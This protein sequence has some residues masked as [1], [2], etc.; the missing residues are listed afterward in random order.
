ML[1]ILVLVASFVFAV[2]AQANLLVNGDFEDGLNGWGS[3]FGSVQVVNKNG[4][5]VA[6]LNDNNSSGLEVLWQSFY[7]PTEVNTVSF[8]FDFKFK[9]W[10]NSR[11]QEDLAGSLLEVRDGITSWW[12]WSPWSI[13]EAVEFDLNSGWMS[14]YGEY[15]VSSIVDIDPNGRVFFGIFE[16]SGWCNDLTDSVLF[17]DNVVVAAVASVPEPGT[18]ALLMLGLAGL[19]FARRKAV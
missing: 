4:N 16:D 18:F 14:F 2:S 19:V 1:R 13:V 3:E 11:H 5:N 9:G 8:S 10:D 17:I 6:K 15:D 7:I 12:D